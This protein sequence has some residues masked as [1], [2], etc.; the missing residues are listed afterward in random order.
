MSSKNKKRSS[1]ETTDNLIINVNKKKKSSPETMTNKKIF[2]INIDI[3]TKTDHIESEIN[4]IE[5]KIS[6]LRIEIIIITALANSI[7]GIILGYKHFYPY[8]DNDF[9][10]S[11]EMSEQDKFEH[12]KNTTYMKSIIPQI[13]DFHA[14][15]MLIK[16]DLQSKS[17]IFDNKVIKIRSLYN[18]LIKKFDELEECRKKLLLPFFTETEKN[19]HKIK[20]KEL[21]IKYEN[22]KKE[23]KIKLNEITEGNK[24]KKELKIIKK[25]IITLTTGIIYIESL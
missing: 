17:D 24:I 23:Y 3:L 22:D 1:H 9:I 25:R 11:G 18:Y 21:E 5:T 15:T 12:E 10:P 20:Y 8:A 19:E 7:I 4:K 6:D 14:R 2:D 16:N 13:R